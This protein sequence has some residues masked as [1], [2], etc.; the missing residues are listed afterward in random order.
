MELLTFI[1][2]AARRKE[3]YIDRAERLAESFSS[4]EALEEEMDSRAAGLQKRLKLEKISF[5]E[6][7]R[8]TAEDTL[9]ASLAA[10]TLGTNGRRATD[11][12]YSEAMGQMQYLWVFFNEIQMSLR[13]GRLKYGEEEEE[14]AEEDDE[15]EIEE[16]LAGPS[17]PGDSAIESIGTAA[18][19]QPANL[20]VPVQGAK[21]L[22]AAMNAAKTSRSE[23][24]QR[25]TSL[26]RS[27]LSNPE[28]ALATAE[29]AARPSN[30]QAGPATWPG[31]LS[32]LK[33]FLVTPLY[34]WFQTGRFNESENQGFREMR[35]ITRKDRK[36]C[37]DCRYYETLGWVPIGSLPMPGVRCQCH[38][39]CRCVIEYR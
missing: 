36:V 8:A 18:G 34:R 3:D 37:T 30:R 23:T 5:S 15:G 2:Q 17:F 16:S 27:E 29:R 13:S 14:F 31:L 38:D 19:S 4:L 25:S 1:G 39:R 26:S 21:S 32:R 10:L 28:A 9:I 12:E 20:T 35:R 11:N 22:T 33:R 6:F 7:Q 24:E